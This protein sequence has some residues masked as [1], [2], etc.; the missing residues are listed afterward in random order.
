MQRKILITLILLTMFFTAG[1]EE[2]PRVILAPDYEMDEYAPTAISEY[3]PAPSDPKPTPTM[4][5]FSISS[6]MYTLPSGAMSFRPPLIWEK[7]TENT[8]Y[9]KFISRDKRA[10]FEA[11]YES[12]G[13]DLDQEAFDRYVDNAINALY[14]QS[15]QFTVKE[16]IQETGRRVITSQF[17]M[18][19]LVWKTRDV[20]I[21]KNYV[22][23]F[24]SFHAL[25]A[26]WEYYLPGF[27]QIYSSLESNTRFVTTD[28]L[29]EFTTV[30]VDPGNI[31]RVRKPIGW[32]ASGV[33]TISE[34][35]KSEVLE[36]PDGLAFFRVLIH[37]PSEPLT[38]SNVGQTAIALLR[39]VIAEDMAFTNDQILPDGRIRLNWTASSIVSRGFSFF[40]LEGYDLYVISFWQDNSKEGIYQQANFQIGDSFKFLK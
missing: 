3:T 32:S 13:Y 27:E 1:C 19:G 40:W 20:F 29:Y 17:L 5:P 18:N 12:T 21:Q 34:G 37:Q 11:G 33:V 23:Y 22:V 39:E 16:D 24:F 4:P 36:A 35:T 15:E 8:N 7:H 2:G 6:S 9:A 14:A 25:Q 38:P 28:D 26:D 31:F 30:Y 10:F